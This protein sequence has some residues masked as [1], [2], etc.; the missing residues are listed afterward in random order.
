[1]S[2][3]SLDPLVSKLAKSLSDMVSSVAKEWVGLDIVFALGYVVG[4]FMAS[5]PSRRS[6]EALEAY[7]DGFLEGFASPHEACGVCD[8]CKAEAART[9]VPPPE[10]TSVSRETRPEDLN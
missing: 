10:E 8:H 4:R 5:V 7:N 9:V 1:M 2:T 3:K 6:A